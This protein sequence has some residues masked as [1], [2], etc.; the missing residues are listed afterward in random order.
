MHVA[1]RGGATSFTPAVSAPNPLQGG[2]GQIDDLAVW[3]RA[4][5]A[6]DLLQVYTVGIDPSVATGLG[7]ALSLFYNFDEGSGGIA[8]NQGRAGSAYDLVLGQSEVGGPTSYGVDNKYG[9]VDQIKLTTPTWGI[10]TARTIVTEASRT[11]DVAPQRDVV[12]KPVPTGFGGRMFVSLKEGE[13]C[14]FIL[15]SF[16]PAGLKSCVRIHA[17]PAHGKLVQKVA[18]ELNSTAISSTPFEVSADAYTSLVCCS[19]AQHFLVT[20][21]IYNA[22]RVQVYTPDRGYSGGDELVYSVY[23]SSGESDRVVFA[24]KF[25]KVD[26]IPHASAGAATVTEDSPVGVR[27]KLNGTDIDSKYTAFILTRLPTKGKL[28]TLAGEPIDAPFSEYQAS[29]CVPFSPLRCPWACSGLLSGGRAVAANVRN[30][31]KQR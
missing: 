30:Y 21:A 29:S 5:T 23:D 2:I 24:F 4:L 9:G 25:Y 15:E 18:A 8:K 20:S 13:S 22:F 28:F 19:I 17:L 1:H 3:A 26:D 11:C 14:S 7:A 12:G 27:I 31:R 16:H 6:D 10:S